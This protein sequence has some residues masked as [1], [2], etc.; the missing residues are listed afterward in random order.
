MREVLRTQDR[1][2]AAE[3][4]LLSATAGSQTEPLPQAQHR[5]PPPPPAPTHLD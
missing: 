2:N 1:A 5:T 3:K 4:R